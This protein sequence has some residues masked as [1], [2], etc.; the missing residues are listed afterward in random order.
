MND[1]GVPGAVPPSD[2]EPNPA[3]IRFAVLVVASSVSV[4]VRVVGPLFVPVVPAFTCTIG[5]DTLCP[6]TSKI[7]YAIHPVGVLVYGST[8][9]VIDAGLPPIGVV[10]TTNV[11]LYAPPGCVDSARFVHVDESESVIVHEGAVVEPPSGPSTWAMTTSNEFA[12]GVNDA[13]VFDVAAVVEL[14][15]VVRF[16]TANATAGYAFIRREIARMTSSG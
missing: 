16:V 12:D 11:P 7:E 5:V 3:R 13:D 10:H 6:V 1:V 15:T 9:T 14:P 4:N 2:D 8:V